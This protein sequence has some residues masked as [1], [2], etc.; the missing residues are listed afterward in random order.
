MPNQNPFAMLFRSRKFLL[1]LAD[2]VV[3]VLMLLATRYLSPNDLDFTK[4][5]I[6]ILQPVVVVLIGS[7]AWEDGKRL[8]NPTV[9]QTVTS[10]T[11]PKVTT[12]A[13]ETPATLSKE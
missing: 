10:G 8:E 3:S 2:A 7:I 12:T 1:T 6:L 5:I 11:N 9:T 13:T 4:Q